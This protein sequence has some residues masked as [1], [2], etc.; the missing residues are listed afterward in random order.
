MGPGCQ[1]SV[2]ILCTRGSCSEE[3]EE[4]DFPAHLGKRESHLKPSGTQL[5]L[6]GVAV[7]VWSCWHESLHLGPVQG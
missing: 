6:A 5:G 2:G 1:F 3:L 4:Q 7:Q